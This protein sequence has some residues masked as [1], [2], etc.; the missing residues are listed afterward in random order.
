METLFAD[1]VPRAPCAPEAYPQ[2]L[3]NQRG[4]RKLV[5]LSCAN[6]KVLLVR[7]IIVVTLAFVT[8][9]STCRT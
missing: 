3:V 9:A 7:K 5:A 6:V 2:G 1:W 8:H 4:R